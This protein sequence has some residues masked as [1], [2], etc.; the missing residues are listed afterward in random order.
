MHLQNMFKTL[1]FVGSALL[2]AGSPL[3]TFGQT[4]VP[5]MENVTASSPAA[6]TDSHPSSLPTADTC[7]ALPLLQQVSRVTAWFAVSSY[8]GGNVEGLQFLPGGTSVMRVAK[9][10]VSYPGKVGLILGAY[11]SNVWQIETVPGT[12]IVGVLA[13]GYHSQRV[14][15]ISA[16]VP[17]VITTA[18]GQGTCGRAYQ[19]LAAAYG[20]KLGFEITATVPMEDGVAFVGE[21]TSGYAPV[22]GAPLP[23]DFASKESRLPHTYGLAQL[24][25]EGALRR[26]TA[27]ELA[28]LPGP[29]RSELWPVYVVLKALTLPRGLYGGNGGDTIFIVP[30]GVP[31]PSGDLGHSQLY[32]LVTKACRRGMG[33]CRLT[34]EE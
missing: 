12:K 1:A 2:A 21:R 17:V 11:E 31:E 5:T 10:R 28:L 24:E 30:A 19:K 34:D 23:S 26:A 14:T 33:D 6:N 8:N 20:P 16:A 25:A 13:S 29:P 15:G 7:E 32:N 9:V 27:K 3:D 18:E 4:S 22:T